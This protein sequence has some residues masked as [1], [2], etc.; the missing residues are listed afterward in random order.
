MG[1]P[2]GKSALTVPS[3]KGFVIQIN[4]FY[5][6]LFGVQQNVK[7]RGG[8]FRKILASLLYCIFVGG[9]FLKSNT[10]TFVL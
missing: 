10:G 9:L 3:Y 8:D 1:A 7:F 5:Y 2:L 6:S 4:D